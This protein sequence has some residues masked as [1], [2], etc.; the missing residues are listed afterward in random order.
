MGDIWGQCSGVD[1]VGNICT[2]ELEPTCDDV[3]LKMISGRWQRVLWGFL[4]MKS[5]GQC[6]LGEVTAGEIE[7]N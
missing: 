6:F 5:R 4:I 7:L 2:A 1:P 3:E